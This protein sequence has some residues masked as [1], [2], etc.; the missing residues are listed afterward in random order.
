M[1]PFD[2]VIQIVEMNDCSFFFFYIDSVSLHV[3]MAQSIFLFYDKGII[4]III[5]IEQANQT[6]TVRERWKLFLFA[7]L[8]IL[9]CLKFTDIYFHKPI[10]SPWIKYFYLTREELFI[11]FSNV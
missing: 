10:I 8:P 6:I 1:I 3:F 9:V 2:P 7:K 4:I 11:F 5:I